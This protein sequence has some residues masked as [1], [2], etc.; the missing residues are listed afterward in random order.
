MQA[1]LEREGIAQIDALPALRAEL[2][3]GR[4]P[5]PVTQDGHPNAAGY[6]AIADAVASALKQ[7]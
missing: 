5:Y 6:A 2:A 1:F 4:Q 7:P 3:A